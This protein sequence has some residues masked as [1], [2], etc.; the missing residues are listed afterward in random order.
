MYPCTGEN[1]RA[2]GLRGATPMNVFLEVLNA[3]T[4]T[5]ASYINL[6]QP[7]HGFN[8]VKCVHFQASCSVV[9]D[10]LEYIDVS[11]RGRRSIDNTANRHSLVEEL[12]GLQLSFQRSTISSVI[13][14]PSMAT[15]DSPM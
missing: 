1:P 13:V 10:H 5:S 15:H 12:A 11:R 6:I 2:N 14:R 7:E 4:G 8:L 3:L 9:F